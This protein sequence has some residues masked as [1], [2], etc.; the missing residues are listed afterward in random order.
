[1]V[2]LVHFK[3][4]NENQDVFCPFRGRRETGPWESQL[5]LPVTPDSVLSRKKHCTSSLQRV[6]LL[7]S[8]GAHLA[9]E[10]HS[11]Q[12]C[13]LWER[14]GDLT[15]SVSCCWVREHWGLPDVSVH[16]TFLLCP[17]LACDVL[18]LFISK[19]PSQTL[20]KIHNCIQCLEFF[21]TN[22]PIAGWIFRKLFQVVCGYVCS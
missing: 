10:V 16:L 19:D 20:A 9:N 5:L 13:L 8:R 2:W 18:C 17:S 12:I 21:S 4:R 22:N 7:S 6:C 11:V 15:S 3:G 1:M 14:R